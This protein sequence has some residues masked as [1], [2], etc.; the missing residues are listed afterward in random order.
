MSI[1]PIEHI[2]GVVNGKAIG[3]LDLRSN[4]CRLVVA[5][6]PNTTYE[7]F[8]SPVSPVNISTNNKQNS[9]ENL[10]FGKLMLDKSICMYT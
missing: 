4:D 3:P 1:S 9:F 10:M 8:M 2:I 7:S 5:I 6:H